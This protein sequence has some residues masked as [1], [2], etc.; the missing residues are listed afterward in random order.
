MQFIRWVLDEVEEGLHV[1][2]EDTIEIL[3]KRVKWENKICKEND[4][5]SFFWPREDPIILNW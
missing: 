1:Q 3:P 5:C 2:E 4:M